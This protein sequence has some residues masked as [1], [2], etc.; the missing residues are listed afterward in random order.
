MDTDLLLTDEFVNFSKSI[1]EIHQAKKTRSEEFKKLYDA[2]KADI[3]NF[4][5]SAANAQK[6]WEEFAATK[7]TK[8]K[9]N[10]VQQPTP[11]ARNA[12]SK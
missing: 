4:D 8:K 12:E 1:A 11:T 6:Q 2:Y 3:K 5:D 7:A 10:D 9:G